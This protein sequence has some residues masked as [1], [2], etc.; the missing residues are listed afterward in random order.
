MRSGLSPLSL[1]PASNSSV[2]SW[3][4]IRI[5][6]PVPTSIRCSR[7]VPAGGGSCG[8]A[9]ADSTRAN[10]MSGCA[11]GGSPPWVGPPW[12]GPCGRGVGRTGGLARDGHPARNSA[13]TQVAIPFIAPMVSRLLAR[14]LLERVAGDALD[15]PRVDPD[16]AERAIE[17]DRVDVPVEHRPLEPAAAA[18]DREPRE[19]DH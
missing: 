10:V 2:K 15:P 8:T 9:A 17:P 16:R 6:S 11:A 14:E 7:H 13:T 4:W 18:R 12:V 5:D 19:L 1:V 3:P